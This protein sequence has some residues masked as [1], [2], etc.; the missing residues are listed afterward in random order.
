M[1]IIKGKVFV[2]VQYWIC[3]EVKCLKASLFLLCNSLCMFFWGFRILHICTRLKGSYF[4]WGRMLS[5]FPC[6]I[7]GIKG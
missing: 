4:L 2:A 5:L 3:H 7:Q 1:I 6:R